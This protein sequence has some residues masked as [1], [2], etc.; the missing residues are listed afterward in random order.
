[1]YINMCSEGQRKIFF[2][3]YYIHVSARGSEIGKIVRDWK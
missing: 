1:M 2:M 3:C